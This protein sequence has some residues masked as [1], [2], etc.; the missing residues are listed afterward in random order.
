MRLGGELRREL[1]QGVWAMSI[2]E[3]IKECPILGTTVARLLNIG[4]DEG[5][6]VSFEESFEFVQKVIEGF[7]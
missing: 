3:G 1:D 2:K 5:F 7:S 4:S 6:W